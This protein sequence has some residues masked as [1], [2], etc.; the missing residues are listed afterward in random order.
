MC[1]LRSSWSMLPASFESS[2][3]VIFGI[4]RQDDHCMHI[5]RVVCHAH[6]ILAWPRLAGMVR[7]KGA[8][9]LFSRRLTVSRLANMRGHQDARYISLSNY[10]SPE[11]NTPAD[12]TSQLPDTLS[13]G[14]AE[15]SHD[16]GRGHVEQNV[17][18][19]ECARVEG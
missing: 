15:G 2:P 6:N 9:L 8:Q 14:A 1:R 10:E 17:V 18:G 5:S 7:G 16:A 12:R 3:G 19:P 13:V 11:I 4:F